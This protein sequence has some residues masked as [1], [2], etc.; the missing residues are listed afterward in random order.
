M[1]ATTPCTPRRRIP[2][3]LGLS[4]ALVAALLAGALA[5]TASAQEGGLEVLEAETLYEEGWLITLSN[6]FSFKDQLYRG[7]KEVRDPIDAKRIDNRTTIGA[8]YGV[9][10][11][12]TLVARFPYVY[13]SIDTD[14]PGGEVQST[15]IGDLTVVGKWRLH[16]STGRRL[17]NNVALLGG[18]ELPTGS[19]T[20]KD[21]G[22]RL[23]PSLQPGS[24]SWDPFAGGAV[25]LERE[26]WKLNAVG[27]YQWNTPGAQDYEFGDELVLD[28]SAGNRFWI[29]RY[30]GPSMSASLGLRWSHTF[31]SYQ[32]GDPVTSTG[33]DVVSLR[34]GTVFH[35]KPVWDLVATLEIPVYHRVTGTQLV[36]RFSLFL[37]LGYRI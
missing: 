30:P 35:P 10:R 16:R 28:L 17:S 12:V 20:E 4:A 23:P 37:G 15:G 13:R 2:R 22:A 33:S 11:D 34:L 21:G 19:T 25:T 29:E 3:R 31:R 26:R 5:P 8:S 9:R 32:D 27:F 6:S 7:E 36:E 14:L 1:S 24:G 18:L